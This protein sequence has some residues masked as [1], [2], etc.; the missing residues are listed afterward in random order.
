M[1]TYR[2][3]QGH[4]AWYNHKDN[5]SLR[6]L[7]RDSNRMPQNTMHNPRD[8]DIADVSK[9]GCVDGSCSFGDYGRRLLEMI[10]G[11]FLPTYR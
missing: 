8:D 1:S 10:E 9:G 6:L 2:D 3:I 11:N 4:I 5:E 7:R